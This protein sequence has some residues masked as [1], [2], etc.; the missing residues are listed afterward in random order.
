MSYTK[1]GT[2]GS[3][4]PGAQG[5]DRPR[6]RVEMRAMT[7]VRVCLALEINPWNP[8]YCPY[9]VPCLSWALKLLIDYWKAKRRKKGCQVIL[10]YLLCPPEL[11]RSSEEGNGNPLQ[12]SCLGNP[13]DRGGRQTAVHG[14]AKLDTTKRL[15]F[16]T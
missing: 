10:A 4:Q 1:E 13:M 8:R 2:Q 6:E 12:Y 5:G 14:V 7:D 15:H 9:V 16:L 11:R 3:C